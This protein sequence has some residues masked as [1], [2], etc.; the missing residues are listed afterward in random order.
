M[1]LWMT[2]RRRMS[3]GVLLRAFWSRQMRRKRKM[4]RRNHRLQVVHFLREK[5]MRET[6]RVWKCSR[7]VVTRD[8]PSKSLWLAIEVIGL[9]VSN[10][11]QWSRLNYHPLKLPLR[12]MKTRVSR[13]DLLRQ[14]GGHLLLQRRVMIDQSR[15]L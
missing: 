6:N 14:V 13:D 9:I 4:I 15:L 10:L 2:W 1:L 3:W 11:R 12:Q 7:L 5:K 8:M